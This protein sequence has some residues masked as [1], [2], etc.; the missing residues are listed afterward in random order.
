MPWAL[1]EGTGKRGVQIGHNRREIG[2]QGDQIQAHCHPQAWR[3]GW[4]PT[5]LRGD[6]NCI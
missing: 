6:V 5:G 4:S 3:G 1:S 2:M